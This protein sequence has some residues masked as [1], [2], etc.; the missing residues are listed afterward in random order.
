MAEFRVENFE[1]G[2]TDHYVNGDPRRNRYMRNILITR[3]RKPKQRNG[4]LLLV[5]D[6][7]PQGNQRI[8]SLFYDNR[9]FFPDRLYLSSGRNINY[10]QSGAYVNL[11]GPTG[12][13]AFNFGDINS[14]VSFDTLKNKIIATIDEYCRPRMINTDSLGF[15]NIV[16]LSLPDYPEDQIDNITPTDPGIAHSYSYA[17]CYRYEYTIG[18]VSYVDYSRVYFFPDVVQSDSPVGDGNT[19]VINDGV[20]VPITPPPINE[21]TENYDLL[22][23]DTLIFRTESNQTTYKL[24]RVLSGTDPIGLRTDTVTDAN[25]GIELYTNSGVLNPN[26]SPLCKYYTIANNIGWS[27]NCINPL[28]GEIEDFRVYHSFQGIL[29]QVP[30]DYYVD[31]KGPVTGISNVDIY[32]VVFESRRTYR[33][34]GV[35]DRLGRGIVR[36]R[37]I[38][39]EIGCISN[40]GIVRTQ[41]GIFFPSV[42]GFYFCDGFRVQKL[43]EHLNDRYRRATVTDLQKTKIT[44][45]RDEIT[46]R[47]YWT[48]VSDEDKTECDS[49]WVLDTYWGLSIESSFTEF[50]EEG[51]TNFQPT[52]LSFIEGDLVRADSRGYLFYHPDNTYTDPTV[53]TTTASTNWT[54]QAVRYYIE[55]CAMSFGTEYG[56]KY[57]TILNMVFKNN[58]N[59]SCQMYSIND[60]SARLKPLK[61]YRFRSNIAWGDDIPEWGDTNAIWY[62]GGLIISKNRFPKNTLRFRYKQIALTNS[63]TIIANSDTYENATVNNVSKTFFLPTEIWPEDIIGFEIYT[64]DDNYTQPFKILARSDDTLTV[65]DNGNLLNNGS[66]QWVIRGVKKNELFELESYTIVFEPFG[67][68]NTSYTIGGD[69]ANET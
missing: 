40:S 45:T 41:R 28:T 17:V 36:R 49:V 25:L 39:D 13:N 21:I 3:N 18:S 12:N 57:A 35:V 64:A 69:G 20:I 42:D 11:L 62:F 65:L 55:S 56:R 2:M 48:M 5:E 10:V 68:S 7:M 24:A 19:N 23:I 16:N 31:M 54:D 33:L 8:S 50:Y 53:D 38:S 51:D 4:S 1:L 67:R 29:G 66:K 47:I 27:A 46:G 43:S 34:E 60:D 30:S 26:E 44:G 63:N 32:P 37:D 6:Q 22:N 14:K 59:I 61:E 9:T 58:S 52:A 15:T